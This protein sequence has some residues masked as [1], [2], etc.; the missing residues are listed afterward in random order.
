MV[1]AFE[2]GRLTEALTTAEQ[3]CNTAPADTPDA[4][5]A[6]LVATF[7]QLRAGQSQEALVALAALRA[8]GPA[9][10]SYQVFLEASVYAAT[11]R[12][13]EAENLLGQLPRG[14]A[15]RHPGFSRVA[16]CWLG[17]RDEARAEQAVIRMQDT[18]DGPERQADAAL[19]LAQLYEARRDRPAAK[20][21]YR[22]LL[23][24]FPLTAASRTAR[25]RLE[26]WESG[27]S[28]KPLSPEE[29]LP[30]AEQERAASRPG[31]ARKLYR[32]IIAQ[33]QTSKRRTLR[34][35]AE[36]GVVELDI[37]DRRY[38]R[39]L[40][41]IETLLASLE[42]DGL[43]T[44]ALYLKAD[45]LSRRGKSDDALS[46]YEQAIA[47][48]PTTPFAAESALAAARLSYNTRDFERAK[49]HAHWLTKLTLSDDAPVVLISG[50]G[51][52]EAGNT[53]L[54]DHGHWLLAFIERRQGAANEVVE[55]LL[56]AINQDG[57]LGPAALY[58]RARLAVERGAVNDAELLASLL[59]RHS[60]SFYA[61]AVSDLLRQTNPGCD[62][63]V[64]IP[65]V[66]TRELADTPAP[67]LEPR[68]LKAVLVLYEHGLTSEAQRLSHL[69]PLGTLNT[70][71]R[72]IAAWL[73]RRCGDVHRAAVL[74]RRLADD[75]DTVNDP[76]LLDL[77][78]PRPFAD[79]VIAA[80]AEHDVPVDLI[81][82]VIRNESAF[83]PRAVSPRHAFGLMQMIRSTANRLAKEAELGPIS[84][85]RLFDPATAIMLGTQYLA[86]LLRRFG[87]NVP[88]ALAAYHAGETNTERW[89][90]SRGHLT[91]DEFIEEIPFSTTRTYVKKVL[92][93][94]GVY[95]LLYQ[96]NVQQAIRMSLPVMPTSALESEAQTP[97][98]AK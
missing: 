36:L 46:A 70:A 26:A 82:A 67:E 84:A 54:A 34:Q 44:R 57:P 66:P 87:G 18:A 91:A 40:K 41:R 52:R 42:D 64:D 51:A 96:D 97:P 48:A 55:G 38:P 19:M 83:N 74:T 32:T 4:A 24:D 8:Q 76:V 15:F 13:D 10:G 37:V 47:R 33:S 86:E 1:Q 61:L 71:D 68:D 28:V 50:D 60:T 85:R 5:Q 3:L 25:S 53:G 45:I 58:W 80:A 72:T 98:V 16:R 2:A 9:L 73:H 21:A 14:S 65:A 20:E 17:T 77:A 35:A 6:R 39:A 75:T 95:R 90:K 29:L 59:T 27:G 62:V 56:S 93:S 63:R 89:L 30:H 94:F 22:Q 7:A 11:K 81:Y 69:V 79:L 88:A 92:A 31:R 43:T 12:C 49:K 23:V 78:Y